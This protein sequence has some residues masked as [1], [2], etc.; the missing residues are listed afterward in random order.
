ML[1]RFTEYPVLTPSTSLPRSKR[2]L[3]E[4]VGRSHPFLPTVIFGDTG[5]LHGFPESPIPCHSL[6]N[7][8]EDQ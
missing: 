8:L 3:Q 5:S 1:C 4:L 2:T 7:G 6:P